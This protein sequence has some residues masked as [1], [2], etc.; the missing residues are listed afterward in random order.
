M[1][2]SCVTPNAS[3]PRTQNRVFEFLF[4]LYEFD[5]YFSRILHA[6]GLRSEDVLDDRCSCMAAAVAMVATAQ[7]FAVYFVSVYRLS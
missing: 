6:T 2:V 3:L 7:S 5:V 4:V 1:C